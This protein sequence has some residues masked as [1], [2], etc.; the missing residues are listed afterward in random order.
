MKRRTGFTLIEL[1][2]V[3]AIIA[4]LAAILFPVFARARAK[5]LANGCLS[6]VKQLTLSI[7]M[8]VGDNDETYPL[9]WSG[10]GACP[11]WRALVFPYVKNAQVYRCPGRQAWPSQLAADLVPGTADR[12]DR[13][14]GING[15]ELQWPCGYSVTSYPNR[16]PIAITS[17]VPKPAETILLGETYGA[18]NA[19]PTVGWWG[20]GASSACLQIA[21]PHS[22][23]SNYGFCDGH[24]KSLMP[25]ATNLTQNMWSVEDDGACAGMTTIL[26]AAEACAGNQ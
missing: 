11:T 15:G 16:M 8:Y 2:V 7:L 4:I 9:A 6:N 24:A 26:A 5:A 3:I 17:T 21:A 25:T 10:W 20:E 23:Q 13:S 19:V 12:F 22:R 1:L 18:N 14:Y